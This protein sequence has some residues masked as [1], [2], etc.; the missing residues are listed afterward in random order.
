V[1]ARVQEATWH[2]SQRVVEQPD[3][4]I[5]WRATIAGTIEVRLWIL[6]WGSDV[7][8]LEPAGLR[9]DVAATLRRALERYGG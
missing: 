4:S 7:E 6:S 1:A 3:G 5:V 9:E 8:V 2:P